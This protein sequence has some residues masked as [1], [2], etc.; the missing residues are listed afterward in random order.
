[1][2][3]AWIPAPAT[4]VSTAAARPHWSGLWRTHQGGHALQADGDLQ[5]WPLQ[6][7]WWIEHRANERRGPRAMPTGGENAMGAGQR[8]WH[9]MN[10]S[11][12]HSSPPMVTKRVPASRWR[13]TQ[14]GTQRRTHGIGPL[15]TVCGREGIVS[16]ALVSARVSALCTSEAGRGYGYT[17]ATP[18]GFGYMVA[19]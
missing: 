1:M 12:N 17:V 18:P 16:E 13:G 14:R 9:P 8:V 4:E 6:T 3:G 2:G 11:E 7:A 10:T 15:G 19:T 5:Q